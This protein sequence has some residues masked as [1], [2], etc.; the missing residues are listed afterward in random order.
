MI[1]ASVSLFIASVILAVCYH[2]Y[3]KLFILEPLKQYNLLLTDLN[4]SNLSFARKININK[5]I[6][7]VKELYPGILNLVSKFNIWESERNFAE[8]NLRYN[9]IK[10]R[11]MADYLPQSIFETDNQGKITYANKAFFEIFGYDKTDFN[12]LISIYSIICPEVVE[13][14][15]SKINLYNVD[16]LALKK[17]GTLLPAHVF[18]S[19]ILK[20]QQTCWN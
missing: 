5:S 4:K 15:F 8:K 6:P 9:L 12:N 7:L 3:V 18:T 10:F 11:E 14:V 13:K 2:F 19:Q 17:D 1:I 16:C 20:K